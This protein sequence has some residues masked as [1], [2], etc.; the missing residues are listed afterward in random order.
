MYTSRH[1]VLSMSRLSLS[2][3]SQLI[4]TAIGASLVTAALL[5]LYN[6]HTRRVKRKQLGQDVL[7]S[8]SAYDSTESRIGQSLGYD[9]T[10]VREQLARNYTF[11]GEEGMQNIRRANIVVVGCGGVGSWAAVML[12]RS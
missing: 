8:L 11:F 7:D 9:E 6:A 4:V 3:R 2:Q 5:N 12:V 10:L 1:N